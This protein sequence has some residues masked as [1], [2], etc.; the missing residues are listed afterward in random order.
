MSGALFFA[1]QRRRAFNAK[2]QLLLLWLAYHGLVNFVGYVF[3]T[4]FA[5]TADAGRVARL[6]GA[7]TP[8]LVLVTVVGWAGLM[9]LAR[10][11]GAPFAELAPSDDSVD[12]QRW[13][14]TVALAPALAATPV[15]AAGF[16][17]VP[18]W[19]SLL[20]VLTTP[21][22]LYD[23]VHRVAAA[24]KRTARTALV[25][26]ARDAFVAIAVALLAW[27]VARVALGRGVSI[28]R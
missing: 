20:Y 7:T 2:G 16:L 21:M 18:H 9:V 23:I 10:P 27:T 26:S 4:W 22:A 12:A 17:P 13:A 5:A 25:A 8:V 15:M 28:G 3:T 24:P 19:L 11:F 6:L 14:R 1:L